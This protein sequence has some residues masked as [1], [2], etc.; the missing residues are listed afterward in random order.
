MK[1]NISNYSVIAWKDTILS[2]SLKD[3]WLY[4]QKHDS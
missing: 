3:L 1:G 4:L 2:L